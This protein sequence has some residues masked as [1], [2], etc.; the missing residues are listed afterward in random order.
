ME[1][2]ASNMSSPPSRPGHIGS[3]QA[4]NGKVGDF[5]K[6]EVWKRGLSLAVSVYRCSSTFPRS[7]LY[8]LTSQMRRAAV[9]ICANL[10]EGYGRR[11][12]TELRRF[13]RI[14][15]GS[16]TELESHLHLAKGLGYPDAAAFESLGTDLYRVQGGLVP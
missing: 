8:G 13:A 12:G 14:S 10:A 15:L 4:R 11:R 3:V 5:R 9:S 7:E 16:A 6:P 2:P 1:L